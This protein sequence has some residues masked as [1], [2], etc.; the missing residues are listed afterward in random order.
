MRKIDLQNLNYSVLPKYTKALMVAL[1]YRDEPSQL[2]S[3]RVLGISEEV[4]I[5]CD[6][7]RKELEILSVSAYFHDIGNLGIPDLILKKPA[8]LNKEDFSRMRD[9]SLIGEEIINSAGFDESEEVA[10]VIRHHHEYFDGQ[11]YPDGL[12]GEEIPV[13]SRIISIADS[14]D[15]MATP[16]LYTR[17]RTHWEIMEILQDETGTKHDPYLMKFFFAIIEKTRFKAGVNI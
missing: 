5:C 15:A 8:H 3:E 16:R 17:A 13:Y 9:H 4:G 6:L 1:G 7:S 12:S 14:Y 10:R 2:H 11:G